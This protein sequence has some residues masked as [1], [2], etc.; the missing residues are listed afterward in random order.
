MKGW[1]VCLL[2]DDEE[3]SETQRSKT[4]NRLN[5]SSFSHTNM[6]NRRLQGVNHLLDFVMKKLP[7]SI[8]VFFFWVQIYI[9]SDLKGVRATEPR[10]NV[11]FLKKTKSGKMFLQKSSKGENSTKKDINPKDYEMHLAGL[12]DALQVKM[13]MTIKIKIEV[14]LQ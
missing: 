14:V 12:D 11:G 2:P 4:N 7:T 6:K 5:A 1:I 10:S 9:A 13:K 3:K 8:H